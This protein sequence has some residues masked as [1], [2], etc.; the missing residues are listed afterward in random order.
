MAPILTVTLPFFALVLRGFAAAA[1]VPVPSFGL[2]ILVLAATLPSASNV[3]LLAERY[4]AD[5]DRV[6]RIILASTVLAFL[7]F[8]LIAWSLGGVAAFASARFVAP[9][10][11]L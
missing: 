10:A 3:S 2:A 5:N 11:P 7:S 8:T 9:H 1:G 6:A 4:G